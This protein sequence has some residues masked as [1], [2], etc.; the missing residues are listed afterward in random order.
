MC[1]AF[2]CYTTN[3]TELIGKLADD[4]FKGTSFVRLSDNTVIPDYVRFNENQQPEINM[5]E[6]WLK[7]NAGLPAECGLK[8]IS[9]EPDQMGMVHYRYHQTYRGVELIHTMYIAHTKNGKLISANGFMTNKFPKSMSPVLSEQTALAKA[10]E[11]IGAKI[12]KWELAS[13]E[14]FIKREQGDA[15][16][17]FFPTGKLVLAASSQKI[18]EA[19]ELAYEFDVYAHEPMQRY[20]IYVDAKTGNIIE[21]L[22][23]IHHGNSNAT[24][25]TAYSGTQTITTDSTAVNNFRLRETGRGLGIETYN[26]LKGTSYGAAVDFTDTDNY[27]NNVNANKDQYACDA[28]LATEKTYDFF[29]TTMEETVLIMQVLSY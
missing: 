1:T 20:Y 14:A 2:L 21:K 28:H 10:K 11:N 18:N 5:L 26:M 15:K 3:A 8:L 23:R 6:G 13:E 12:Y 4:R 24:C 19:F 25:V 27:W 22:D 16:A 7:S 17:T 9:T 29:L